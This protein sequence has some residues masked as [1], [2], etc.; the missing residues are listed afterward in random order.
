M[1]LTSLLKTTQRS[2]VEIRSLLDTAMQPQLRSALETQLREYESI[3]AEAF[4]IA[5]QRGWDLQEMDIVHRFL[6][7][8][9]TR[10][11]ASGCNSDSG[12]AGLLIQMNTMGMIRG[13]QERNRIPEKDTRIRIL[14][15]KL[16]DCENA[17]IRRMQSFL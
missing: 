4:T 15:Q 16:L 8:R 12:I 1:I 10:L 9:M 14:S 13:I 6:A 2:Q 11:K 7:D 3:E 17:N 5:L